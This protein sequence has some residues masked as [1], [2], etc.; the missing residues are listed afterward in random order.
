[1]LVGD[2]NSKRIKWPLEVGEPGNVPFP[3]EEPT[4]SIAVGHSTKE[5]PSVPDPVSTKTD[6]KDPLVRRSRYD[7]QNDETKS[8]NEAPIKHSAIYISQVELPYVP[9]LVNDTFTKESLDTGAEKSFISEEFEKPWLF[10]DLANLE[11]PCILEV[12][13]INGSKIILDFDRKSLAIPDS[14][15]ETVAK[16]IEEGNVEI[17]LSET[18]LKG[19]QKQDLFDYF[20]GLFLDKTCLTHVLYSEIDTGDMPTVVSRPYHY[21]RVK[22]ALLYYHVEKMLKEETI[23]PIQS[24]YA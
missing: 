18:G 16:T 23:I 8:A 22:Q 1:M 15:I 10:P 11:Y 14:Q 4:P 3:G 17:Y 2:T 19:K 12:D 24:P 21:D 5:T 6:H 7:D 13:F 9:I 20:K